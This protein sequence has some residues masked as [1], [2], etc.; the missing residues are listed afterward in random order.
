M[1]NP[2]PLLR[3]F[4]SSSFRDFQLER[5][6]LQQQVFPRLRQFC[7]SRDARFQAIDLRWGINEEATEN[8]QTMRMC[9][10]EL[11]RCQATTPRPNFL[12]LLGDRY[13]W[14]PLPAEIPESE[15]QQLFSAI[16]QTTTSAFDEDMAL[17]N[18]WYRRD[19]NAVPPERV[20]QARDSTFNESRLRV[21]LQQAASQAMTEHDPRRSKYFDSAT[22]Q[23]IRSGALASADAKEHVFCYSRNLEVF[24]QNRALSDVATIDPQYSDYCD[25]IDDGAWDVDA[26]Q[27]L[28][29]LKSEIRGYL[30]NH[31]RSFDVST[32]SDQ[33]WQDAFAEAIF[34]DLSQVIED[35]LQ[36]RNSSTANDSEATTHKTF[37]G[38]R[39][40]HF[41]G[42]LDERNQI[43]DYLDDESNRQPLLVTGTGGSG[44]TSLM[45][46]IAADLTASSLDETVTISRFIG[47]TPTASDVRS[48]LVSLCTEMRQRMIRHDSGESKDTKSIPSE[49]N[50]LVRFF[51]ESLGMATPQRKLVLILD[52]LDQLNSTDGAHHLSW[53]PWHEISENCKIIVSALDPTD[54]S[55]SS[56]A[57]VIFERVMGQVT[58]SNHLSLG[59]MTHSQGETLLNRWLSDAARCLTSAQQD[60]IIFGF[61]PEQG[62]GGLPLWL[63]LAFE[64]ARRWKSYDSLPMG[65]DDIPGLSPDVPGILRDLFF[66]L[67]DNRAHGEVL[68]RRALG[69]L[70]A[71]RRGLTE[72]ELIDVLSD[73][74][75]V[76]QDFALRS[77]TER[78]STQRQTRLPVLIWSRLH[79][80]L[81][82]YLTD[83]NAFGTTVLSFYHRQVEEEVRKKYLNSK[84]AV[85]LHRKLAEYFGNDSRNPYFLE[86]IEAQREHSRMLPPTPRPVN[87]R[88]VDE[89]S[90]S[91]SMAS[92]R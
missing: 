14:R 42:R 80:D 50:D 23:E 87:I 58:E 43:A 28:T 73:D 5:E 27:R 89:L 48:L 7:E 41:T 44:K 1:A 65:H 54:I 81:E 77:P 92:L 66:R 76:M 84:D 51:L 3:V 79:G 52:A 40:L 22:H 57:K 25:L 83:R 24:S 71:G 63:K 10:D 12:M 2:R 67:E 72:D 59:R 86:D 17:L 9:L 68:T 16:E 32:P 8:H 30:G 56:D 70:A 19:D 18:R 38:Q 64:E 88:K 45:A 15:F 74:E 34:Q 69:Y 78:E 90:S 31:Y 21:I 46:Q 91:R 55:A 62:G 33:T 26:D 82:P 36:L 49:M 29:A 39:C 35:S 61:D 13:G 11:H 47:V 37:G 6:L 4:I 53:L 85:Y 60:S 20:L 75:E